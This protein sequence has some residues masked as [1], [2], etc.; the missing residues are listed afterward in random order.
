MAYFL[1]LFSYLRFLIA[2]GIILDNANIKSS[3]IPKFK[4]NLDV[5]SE[6]DS[7]LRA[8]QRSIIFKE[9]EMLKHKSSVRPTDLENKS[10]DFF[11]LVYHRCFKIN[12]NL[13]TIEQNK[14]ISTKSMK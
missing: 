10:G 1:F 13:N 5:R 8:K 4:S 7:S 3:V 11:Y 2:F 6:I 12:A 14:M 9:F